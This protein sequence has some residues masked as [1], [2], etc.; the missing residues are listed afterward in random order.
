MRHR[1]SRNPQLFKEMQP[2]TQ[3]KSESAVFLETQKNKSGPGERCS[4]LTL[5]IFV[6][7]YQLLQLLSFLL[8]HLLLPVFHVKLRGAKTLMSVCFTFSS[9][10]KTRLL[11]HL[12]PHRSKVRPLKSDLRHTRA[13]GLLLPFLPPHQSNYPL[14]PRCPLYCS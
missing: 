10:S 11:F 13:D 1:N 3:R 2:V 5:L 14:P 8:L 12:N 4:V 9:A 7:S 6:F